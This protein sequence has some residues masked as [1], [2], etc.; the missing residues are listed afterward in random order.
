MPNLVRFVMKDGAS[1]VAACEADHRQVPQTD[2]SL[3]IGPEDNASPHQFV[4]FVCDDSVENVPTE[5]VRAIFTVERDFQVPD[6]ST[7]F[8]FAL[9][10]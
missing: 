10:A 7:V 6:D 8:R 3:A 5:N 2:L 4:T 1:I 9:I